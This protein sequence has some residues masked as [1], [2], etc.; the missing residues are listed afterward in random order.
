MFLYSDFQCRDDVS[1]VNQTFWDWKEQLASSKT[2]LKEVCLSLVN[3]VEL[4]S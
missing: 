4:L 1:E 3:L 2:C